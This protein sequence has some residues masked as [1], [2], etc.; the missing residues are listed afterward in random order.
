M[1]IHYDWR[2]K[3]VYVKLHFIIIYNL[4][5]T[6]CSVVIQITFSKIMIC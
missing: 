4:I 3:I 6:G 2:T 5:I 1:L